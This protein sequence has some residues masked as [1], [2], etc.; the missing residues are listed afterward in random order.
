[1]V[2]LILLYFIGKYFYDLAIKHNKHK[3]GYAILGIAAYYA[4]AIVLGA[5][6]FI[7]LELGEWADVD[8][9]DENAAGL[10]AMPFGLLTCWVLYALLKRNW[11]KRSAKLSEDILDA[12]EL[13]RF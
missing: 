8:A 2:G 4:G 7:I 13:G 12:G 5:M 3:W 11:S 9:I 6:L 10:I 1:M